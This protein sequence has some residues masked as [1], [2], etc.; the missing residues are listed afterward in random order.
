MTGLTPYLHFPG[1]AQEALTFYADTFNCSVELHTFESS[2]ERTGRVR[3]SRTATSV[4]SGRATL[5]MSAVTSPLPIRRE[6]AGPVGYRFSLL[7]EPGSPG[8]RKAVGWWTAGRC[9]RGEHP[10]VRSLTVTDSTGLSGSKTGKRI[11]DVMAQAGDARAAKRA[12]ADSLSRLVST[13]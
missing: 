7:S 12:I 11:E 8:L 1:T 13:L 5:P 6:D 3:P 9:G 2:R 4:R 10:I